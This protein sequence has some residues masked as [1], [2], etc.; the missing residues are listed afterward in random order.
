MNLQNAHLRM[1]ILVIKRQAASDYSFCSRVRHLFLRLQVNGC[2]QQI[3]APALIVSMDMFAQSNCGKLC[4]N[5]PYRLLHCAGFRKRKVTNNS[6][7]GT[8]CLA[9]QTENVKMVVHVR[10][11]PPVVVFELN[12]KEEN[13]FHCFLTFS[14]SFWALLAMTTQNRQQSLPPALR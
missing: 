9:W 11:K 12:E 4:T 6:S 3:N 13:K 8:I 1:F 2:R 5:P 10:R 7:I 14:A